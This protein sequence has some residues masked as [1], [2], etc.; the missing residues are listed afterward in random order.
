MLQRINTVLL[1]LTLGAV[2][3]FGLKTDSKPVGRYSLALDGTGNVTVLDTTNGE[4]SS[5]SVD[6][7]SAV[8]THMD[9]INERFRVRGRNGKSAEVDLK[10]RAI[11]AP[12]R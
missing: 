1:A 5:I 7:G 3:W 12:K 2:L 4:A 10:K 9:L 6:G 11:A 8:V